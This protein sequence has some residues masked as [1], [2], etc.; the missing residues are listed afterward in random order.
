MGEI[1]LKNG[2]VLK[3]CVDDVT[4]GE[5]EIFASPKGSVAQ[6]R[7][8]VAKC[9]GLSIDEVKALSHRV[10]YIPLIKEIIREIREPLADPN[11]QSVSTSPD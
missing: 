11:S 8:I 7:E 5:W 1:A 9:T 6:E 10:E 4:N 3:I 2:K